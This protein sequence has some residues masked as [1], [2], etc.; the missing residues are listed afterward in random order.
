MRAS[1]FDMYYEN[2]YDSMQAWDK[3]KKDYPNIKV[4]TFPKTVIKDMK[5]ATDKYLQDM[6]KKINYL[7]KYI[8]T[9]KIL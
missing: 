4:K 5:K 2:F 8:K 3:M 1:S 6:Q 9:N 7:K